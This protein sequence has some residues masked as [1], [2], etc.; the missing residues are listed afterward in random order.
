MTIRVAS[1][2]EGTAFVGV[3]RKAFRP[4]LVCSWA[5][6]PA[7]HRLSCTWTVSAE[8]SAFLSSRIAAS[9]LHA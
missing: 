5:L 4:R 8:G 3:G 1:D 2:I 7:S 6:D 9:S